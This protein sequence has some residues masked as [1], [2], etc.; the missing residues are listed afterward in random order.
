MPS[1]TSTLTLLAVAALASTPALAADSGFYVG[2]GL[3]QST[4]QEDLPSGDDFDESD[5]GWKAF[6]GYRLG[7]YI[8]IIDFAGELTYRDFGNP[9]GRGAEF[10]ATGYDASALGIVTLG[11]IDLFARLGL[12]RYS[13]ES[14]GAGL[15]DDDDSTS[16]IYGLGA[17]FRIGKI[18]VRVEW[19]RVEPD[20]VDNIDMYSINAYWRF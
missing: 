4:F 10:E 13:V 20:G 14:D 17:G 12:G 8:P 18:N 1:I 7:G 16:E 5:T 9:D 11:P 19:E 6:V 3:G 2:G 15:N